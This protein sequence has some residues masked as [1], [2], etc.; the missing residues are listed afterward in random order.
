MPGTMNTA[1]SDRLT[2]Y[3]HSLKTGSDSSQLQNSTTNQEVAKRAE[4]ENLRHN[5]AIRLGQ[6]WVQIPDQFSLQF[7]ISSRNPQ[8]QDQP[9]TERPSAGSMCFVPSVLCLRGQ[10]DWMIG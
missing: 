8:L 9:V 1:L 5:L 6:Y 7:N 2:H 3:C 10:I 4:K